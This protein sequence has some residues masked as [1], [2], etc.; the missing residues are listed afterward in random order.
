MG[1]DNTNI[2]IRLYGWIIDSDVFITFTVFPDKCSSYF[3]CGIFNR[4]F[5]PVNIYANITVR[6]WNI[7][8]DLNIFLGRNRLL[9][10]TGGI[11]TFLLF[12]AFTIDIFIAGFPYCNTLISEF[13]C[14][15]FNSIIQFFYQDFLLFKLNT[16]GYKL[17]FLNSSPFCSF[18][19]S[20]AF[21]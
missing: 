9:F 16:L 3:L 14:D 6:C 21:W 5:F 10:A 1:F 4:D 15:L 2:N 8:A 13:S 18:V 7:T 20:F 19:F 11:D 17:I 12:T